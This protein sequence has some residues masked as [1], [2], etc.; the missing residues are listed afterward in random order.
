MK[1][2]TDVTEIEVEVIEIDGKKPSAS[3]QSHTAEPS[4]EPDLSYAP[5][6]SAPHPF[7][8]AS[9]RQFQSWPVHQIHP[10]WWPFI[11]LFGG[12]ALA[13]ILFIALIIGAFYLCFKIIA[14][15][16]RLLFP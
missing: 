11:V 7:P 1:P 14:S 16:L 13:L 3:T 9:K 4:Q 6:S 12:I 2:H 8:N 10:F 15:T 5:S